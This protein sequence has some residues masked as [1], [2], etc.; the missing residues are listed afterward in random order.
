MSFGFS[1]GDLLAAGKL[2]TEIIA[3]L[4]AVGGARSEYQELQRELESLDRALRHVDKLKGSAADGIKCAALVCRH[5]LEE[6][7]RKIKKHEKSLGLGKSNGMFKDAARKLEWSFGRKDEISKLRDYL[8]LHVSSVNMLLMTHGLDMLDCITEQADQNQ[9]NIQKGLGDSHSAIVRLD[10]TMQAQNRVVQDSR[11]M[12]RRLF[13]MVS[14][15]IAAPLKLMAEMVSKVWCVQFIAR[16][17]L[18]LTTSSVTTQQVYGIVI[19]LRASIPSIDTRHT[20]FQAPVKVEDALGRIFPV[21]SEYSFDDLEAIVQRRFRK[22]PG[23]RQ[24]TAGDYE[25]YNARNTKQVISSD[26]GIGLL[27]GMNVTMAIYINRSAS[28][29]DYCPMPRCGSSDT[30]SVPGGGRTW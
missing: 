10:T 4:R 22:G 11:S 21:P 26:S 23:Q 25:F 1:V 30:S 17:M 6:F 15:D 28:K 20:F 19:E 27:P 9:E 14:G 12:L 18:C 2:I 24:V 5:P 16:A 7:Q 8:S 29:D 13:G 3:S